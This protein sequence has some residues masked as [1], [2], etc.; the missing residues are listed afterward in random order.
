M[1]NSNVS[2]GSSDTYSN[3][4]KNYAGKP[5]IRPVRQHQSIGKRFP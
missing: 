4:G 5:A 3:E 2:L 1:G